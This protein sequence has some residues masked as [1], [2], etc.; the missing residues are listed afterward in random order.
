VS[1]LKQ[2]KTFTVE[3]L[4]GPCGLGMVQ[5]YEVSAEDRDEA[6]HMAIARAAARGVVG[7]PA[8]LPAGNNYPDQAISIAFTVWEEDESD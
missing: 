4:S 6:L 1:D 7:G 3:E 2:L 8:M 5:Q